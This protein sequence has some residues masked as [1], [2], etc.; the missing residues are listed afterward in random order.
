MLNKIK[1]TITNYLTGKNNL[2]ILFEND[3]IMIIDK[4]ADLLVHADGVSEDTSLAEILKNKYPE[5][6]G[7]GEDEDRPGIV[8]RLDRDTTGVL[9]LCKTKGAYSDM[10]H[11]FKEHL[12]KKTYKAIIEGNIR[13]DI[14]IIDYKIARARSDFRKKSIVD[15]RNMDVRGEE[16]EAITRYKVVERSQDKKHTLIEC[17][18]ETGRTH[19]IRVHLRGIRHPIIGDRL[20]GSRNGSEEASRQ[21][22]HSNKIEFT[23]RG[24]KISV[25]SP[26]PKD[27]EK[28]WNS[29]K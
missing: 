2:N 13:D 19:Q 23:L 6:I 11:L 15:I 12:I 27:F 17:Y 8:H 20:Y 26:I 1:Q 10:K 25:T 7:V 14:G 18:P 28:F 3:L 21:M 29:V 9:V 22:L 16:R 5:F 24:D 4:P